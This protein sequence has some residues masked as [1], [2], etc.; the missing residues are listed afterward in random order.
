MS[1]PPC[2]LNELGTPAA[3]VVGNSAGVVAEL[4][5]E[6]AAV[7]E[8]VGIEGA[9]ILFSAFSIGRSVASMEAWR[10]TERGSFVWGI[11]VNK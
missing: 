7:L 2:L 8:A 11:D 10:A 3:V 4:Q 6:E 5:G 9:G 1:L